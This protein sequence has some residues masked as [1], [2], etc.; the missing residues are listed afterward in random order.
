VITGKRYEHT[1]HFRVEIFF[2]QIWCEAQQ[3]W[4]VGRVVN[5]SVGRVN[6]VVL[7]HCCP[8]NK[9]NCKFPFSL[10]KEAKGVCVCNFN[11]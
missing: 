9:M 7:V 2:V 5:Q 11:H 6:Q 8:D 1:S 10:G 4:T 3:G